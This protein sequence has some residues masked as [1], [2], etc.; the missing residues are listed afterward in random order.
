[1]SG[2]TAEAQAMIDSLNR[3]IEPLRAELELARHREA[4]F[5]ELAAR[6]S[7]LDIPC[8]RE[9]LREMNHV[10]THIDHLTV[11]PSVI[12]LHVSGTENVRLSVGRLGLDQILRDVTDTFTKILQPTDILG[13]LGGSDFGVILL[14]GDETSSAETAEKLKDAIRTRNFIW[15]SRT[16]TLDVT[17]GMATLTAGESAEAVLDTADREIRL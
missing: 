8:R 2:M 5:C 10:L 9:F 13:S 12:M 17:Y 7:F 14:S 3:Q 11:P 6:H 1:M 16:F 4:H 15:A